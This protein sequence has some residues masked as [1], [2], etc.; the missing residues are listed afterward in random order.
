MTP[1]HRDARESRWC[2]P[3]PGIVTLVPARPRDRHAGARPAPGSSRWC[4][5]GPGIVTLVPAR[6]GIYVSRR[7]SYT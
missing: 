3:G 2:P 6:P 7:P 1:A 5:P 4:P